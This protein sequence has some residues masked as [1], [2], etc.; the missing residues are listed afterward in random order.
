LKRFQNR[1]FHKVLDIATTGSISDPHIK[2]LEYALTHTPN[3]PFQQ[4]MPIRKKRSMK[5]AGRRPVSVTGLSKQP[6]ILEASLKMTH[7]FRFVATNTFAATPITMGGI[8]AAAGGIATVA[9]T[10]VTPFH[11]CARIRKVEL[12]ANAGG[13]ESHL[14]IEWASAGL[15]AVDDEKIRSIVGVSN[16]NYVLSRP[17]KGSDAARPFNNATPATSLFLVT[18]PAAAVIDVTVDLWAAN[19][20]AS[21][22]RG[23]ATAILGTIYYMALDSVAAAGTHNFVP[24]GLPTTF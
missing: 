2:E 11:T 19:N 12:F 18:G 8:L 16:S 24:E 17:P 9:N 20:F 23:A 5:K 22:S 14:F 7:T 13:A 6:P 1:L 21:I 4:Y 15:F 3:R 10:T